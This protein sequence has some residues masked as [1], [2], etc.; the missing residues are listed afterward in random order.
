MDDQRIFRVV[1]HQ[2][3]IPL[4]ASVH[5][6]AMYQYSIKGVFAP[7]E[8]SG[9]DELIWI[10]V[11]RSGDRAIKFLFGYKII[12]HCHKGIRPTFGHGDARGKA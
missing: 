6:Y 2:M 7:R 1:C 3:L 4:N 9:E 5:Q 12:D 11:E 8:M 10:P